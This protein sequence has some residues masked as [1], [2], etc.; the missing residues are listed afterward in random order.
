MTKRDFFILI[1]KVFGL[2]S[3]V[4]SVF[5]TLP[6]N[7]IFIIMDATPDVTSFVWLVTAAVVILSLFVLLVFQADKV[8]SLLKLDKGFDE[9]R[10]D[11]ANLSAS[12]IVKIATFIIGGFLLLDNVPAFLSY[13]LFAFKSSVINMVYSDDD[14]F[15]LI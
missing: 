7:F 14:K 9:D 6:S 15:H 10:I 3:L 13:S 8:V 11:L 2:F 5:S 1:I 12:S 4:T